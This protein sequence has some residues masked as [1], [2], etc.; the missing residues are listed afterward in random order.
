MLKSMAAQSTITDTIYE[1]FLHCETKAYLLLQ[2]IT[3]FR[4]DFEERQ[5]MLEVAYKNSGFQRLRENLKEGDYFIG[6]PTLDDLRTGTYRVIFGPL[7][8]S[9]RFDLAL[10]ALQRLSKRTTSVDGYGPIRFVQSEKP[11]VTDKLLIAL[12]AI[13]ISDHTG[14]MPRTGKLIYGSLFTTTVVLLP[15]LVERAE[16]ILHRI[17]ARHQLD[18]S[19]PLALNSHCPTCRFQ[20]RC[21]DL[22]L[23]KDDLSLLPN[24][25]EE[26]RRR[27]MAKGIF[28]VTQ[29]S[30]TYRPRRRSVRQGG[31]PPKHDSALKALAIRK[32][33]IHVIGAPV[34]SVQPNAVYLDVEGLPDR[35]FYYLIGLRR[36]VGDRDI[37]CSF[38]ADSPAD[39]HTI[40][41]A[42][43]KELATMAAP[44][45][46]H[47]GSYETVFLKRM[48]SRYSR[49]DK[50]MSDVNELLSSAINLL[51]FTYSQIYFPTY[52]NSLKDIAGH[53]G[54]QWSDGTAS[55]LKSILWRAD[56]ETSRAPELK[57]KLLIYN[58]EDCEAVQKLAGILEIVCAE[59]PLAL[60][61]AVSVN[62]AG[63]ERDYRQ[64]FGALRYALPAFKPINEAAYWDYQRSRVYARSNKLIRKA[65]VSKSRTSSTRSLRLS[66][67]IR[68]TE[69]RPVYCKTCLSRR[70]YKN[71]RYAHVIYDLRF[72]TVGVKR[73]VTKVEFNSYTCWNCKSRHNEIARQERYGRALRVY[74]MYQLIELRIS[75]K[76]IARHIDTL[77]DLQISSSSMGRIKSVL[78]KEYSGIYQ[79]ILNRMRHGKF[80][81][82]DETRVRMRGGAG[83]VWAFATAEDVAYIFS[84]TREASVPKN[85]LKDF[86][87]VLITDFYA[88][89]EAMNCQQQKCLIHLLRDINEDVLKN[90][91]NEEMERLAYGFASLLK[92]IIETIDRF[93]LK[94]R[95]LQKHENAV[96]RFYRA[97][98]KDECRTEVAAGYKKRFEKSRDRLFTFLHHDG[99]PWNN[100][101]AEHAIKAFAE[102]R[103]GIGPNGTPKS[104]QE[105]LV[106]VSVCET[107]RYRG[108]EFLKFLRSGKV[109]LEA[110]AG[111]KAKQP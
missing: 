84:E 5:A 33:R 50:E 15:N 51:S 81:H 56:W 68:A 18:A 20:T 103:G 4:S 78:A 3:G 54:F 99:V 94:K 9:R 104:I 71:G 111:C 1:A 92:P 46:I 16:S 23:A 45:L 43:L 97:L 88:A 39:E 48:R 109:D 11:K 66:K 49:T 106:L 62:V 90:P 72:S 107:C 12:D 37:Q 47:Y 35:E 8:S 100:N 6:T 79:A 69:A 87:G 38:W 55:G 52:S 28:T 110:D 17:T 102:L 75:Q 60:P 44:Q 101:N 58:A 31:K 73:W 34:F 24:M 22:A 25:R 40:W 63:M 57:E 30:Y 2:G 26:E 67:I 96:E 19:P 85:V 89:Y 105:Y 42:C 76:A 14:I 95:F 91:F 77:F 59:Q 65:L 82:V 93:G 10:H 7:I 53:I 61:R 98:R 41:D 74:I 64:R 29:L 36:R 27:Y 83:Y 86:Q 80:V 32:N 13:A 70:I 108:I 21:R